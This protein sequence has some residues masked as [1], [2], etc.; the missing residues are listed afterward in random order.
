M[1]NL[2][3][4]QEIIL[5]RIF[6]ALCMKIYKVLSEIDHGLVFTYYPN[7]RPKPSLEIQKNFWHRTTNK[8]RISGYLRI[9]KINAYRFYP[10][11]GACVDWP[12]IPVNNII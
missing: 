5:W 10:G 3:G 1:H 12:L 8:Y 7:G 4:E 9:T 11:K 2:D 6:K